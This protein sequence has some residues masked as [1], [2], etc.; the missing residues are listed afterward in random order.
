[1]LNLG[2]FNRDRNRRIFMNLV[3][4]DPVPKDVQATRYGFIENARRDFDS[5]FRAGD[6]WGG[7][8]VESRTRWRREVDSNCRYRFANSEMT[9]SR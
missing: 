8:S 2:L 5:V 1:M 9:A 3:H 6:V 7:E 4:P